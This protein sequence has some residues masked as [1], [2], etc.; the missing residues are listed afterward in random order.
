[1]SSAE[2]TVSSKLA[3][4]ASM[5]AVRSA[6][7][8]RSLSCSAAS[9]FDCSMLSRNTSSD[10]A[11]SATSSRV[12][13]AITSA[14]RSPWARRCITLCRLPMRRRML[15]PT[16]SHTNNSEPMNAAAPIAIITMI[17]NDVR[18]NAF[19]DVSAVLVCTSPTSSFTPM[20]RNELNRCVSSRMLCPAS[21]TCSS[22]PRRSKMPSRPSPNAMSLVGSLL[23]QRRGEQ[24][25]H[26]LDVVEHLLARGLEHLLGIVQRLGSGGRS[27]RVQR[28][29]QQVGI[30]LQIGE[31]VGHPHRGER[32][33]QRALRHDRRVEVRTR[34]G[35]GGFDHADERLVRAGQRVELLL[36]LGERL[37]PLPGRA[38]EIVGHAGDVLQV[39]FQRGH[40]LR[41]GAELPQVVEP[42]KRGTPG[43]P[44]ASSAAAGGSL[45][46]ARSAVSVRSR[47]GSR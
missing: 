14:S 39:L 24:L 9:V 31:R 15:R 40:D 27:G 34:F 13:D 7:A 44:S 1:M 8:A 5:R 11:I 19:S 18:L 43:S 35:D 10:F 38:V 16:Y 29:G 42:R 41:I 17:A 2:R 20:A 37:Q 25:A 28:A 22:L 6:F 36:A 45:P 32:F 47:R 12:L 26:D 46:S 3:M 33:L 21:T 23:D 4:R 30:R